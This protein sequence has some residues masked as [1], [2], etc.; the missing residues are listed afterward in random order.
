MYGNPAP[1]WR[2]W[3][4]RYYQAV[5]LAAAHGMRF[6]FVVGQ[7]GNPAGTLDQ[8]LSVAGGRLRHATEA[9]EA[10]NEVDNYVGGTRGW[11]SWLT[12]YSRDLYRKAKAQPGA[13][14]AARPR[15]RPSARPMAPA[16]SATSAR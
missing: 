8:L 1:A 11:A 9:L 6:D 12:A 10:P 14:H 2:D 7:P 5:E 4:E 3:N 16:G 15:A 13:A